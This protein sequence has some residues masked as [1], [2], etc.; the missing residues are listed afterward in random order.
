MCGVDILGI[1]VSHPELALAYASLV[2]SLP[3]SLVLVSLGNTDDQVVLLLV[4]PTLCFPVLPA[5][6]QRATY[7]EGSDSAEGSDAL[8]RP[9][10]ELDLDNVL[11]GLFQS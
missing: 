8:A 5:L 9:M 2:L 6:V 11:L 1:D 4:S 10:V 7:N 3:D